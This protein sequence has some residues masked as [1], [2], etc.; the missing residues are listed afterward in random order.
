[1]HIFHVCAGKGKSLWDPCSPTKVHRGRD[2]EFIVSS[3]QPTPPRPPPAPT[4]Q[5]PLSPPQATTPGSRRTHVVEPTLSQCQQ[6]VVYPSE[7]RAHILVQLPG[8]PHGRSSCRF[9]S[10]YALPETSMKWIKGGV[11]E[12]KIISSLRRAHL[13]TLPVWFCPPSWGREENSSDWDLRFYSQSSLGGQKGRK[14]PGNG[15][16][17][18]GA[19]VLSSRGQQRWEGEVVL[20]SCWLLSV[21]PWLRSAPEHKGNCPERRS[22]FNHP[23]GK[24]KSA[25]TTDLACV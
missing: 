21:F 20:R 9:Y 19:L 18:A 4:T 12:A 8:L 13:C 22:M 24:S 6:H 23:E 7:P 15:P 2:I 10:V 3:P 25:G 14:P 17:A 1:M 5:P 11:C 16:S